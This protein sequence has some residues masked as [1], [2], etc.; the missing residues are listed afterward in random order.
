MGHR[1]EPGGANPTFVHREYDPNGN[2][3]ATSIPTASTA[4]PTDAKQKTT[5]EYFDPGWIKMSRDPGDNEVNFDYSAEGWQT[6]RAPENAQGTVVDDRVSTWEYWVDGTKKAHHGRDGELTE[7][8]YDANNNVEQADDASGATKDKQTA[9]DIRVGY[10]GLDRPS[11]VRMRKQ[12]ES[13]WRVATSEYDPDGNVATR[14]DDRR[15]DDAGNVVGGDTGRTHRFTYFP[16]GWLDEHLDSGRKPDTGADDRRTETDY[17]PTGLEERRLVQKAN[18]AGGYDTKQTLTWEY[19]ANGQ[20][21]KT[22]VRNKDGAVVESHEISYLAD[23][24]YAN[25]HRVTDTFTRKSPKTET[26]C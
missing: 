16:N 6:R 11:R 2:L 13:A 24:A 15:E 8:F 25:G 9:V 12:G 3:T 19:F 5:V 21:R 14:V 18:G 20:K 10:D 1:S 22:F 23:G 7:Y 17:L 4:M 26:P